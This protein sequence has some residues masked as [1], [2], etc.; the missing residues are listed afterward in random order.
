MPKE[1]KRKGNYN[2]REYYQHYKPK[3]GWTPDGSL[4]RKRGFFFLFSPVETPSAH[5]KKNPPPPKLG[6]FIVLQ[7]QLFFYPHGKKFSF[8]CF[9]LFL[10][11]GKINYWRKAGR[12]QSPLCLLSNR[13]FGFLLGV[14]FSFKLIKTFFHPPFPRVPLK[15]NPPSLQALAILGLFFQLAFFNNGAPWGFFFP[16][17]SGEK[18]RAIF[19]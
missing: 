15:K 19:I 13:A 17:W 7:A 12:S 10:L 11:W 8:F 4:D 16:P 5:T 14:F 3:G 1:I 9:P 2:G 18:V 6:F